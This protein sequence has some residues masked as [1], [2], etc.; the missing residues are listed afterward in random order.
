VTTQTQADSTRTEAGLIRRAA[1]LIRAQGY[2][3]SSPADSGPGYSASS[4]LCAAVGCNDPHLRHSPDCEGLHRRVVGYLYLTGQVSTPGTY[5][6]RVL[7]TWEEYQLGSGYR[8]QAEVLIVL[9]R[10]AAILAAEAETA[11]PRAQLGPGP[12]A[13]QDTQPER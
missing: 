4:A 5:M 12:W 3:P 11:R 8:D 9:E 6:P 10:S 1:A 13:A 7:E 2:N